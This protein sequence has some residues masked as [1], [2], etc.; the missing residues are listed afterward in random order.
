MDILSSL[1]SL[2]IMGSTC[3][4]VLTRKHEREDIKFTSI[5]F[6]NTDELGSTSYLQQAEG[7]DRQ[8]PDNSGERFEILVALGHAKYALVDEEIAM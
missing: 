8:S 6:R 4:V 1:G 7:Q 2:V 3:W 5:P